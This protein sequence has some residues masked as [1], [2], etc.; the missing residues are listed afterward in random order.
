MKTLRTNITTTATATPVI[1]RRVGR[2]AIVQGVTF[3]NV[4][5]I[6]KI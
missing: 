4:G 1:G 2:P 3:C 5:Y 6:P